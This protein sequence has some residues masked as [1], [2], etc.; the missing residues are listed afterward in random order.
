[1]VDMETEHWHASGTVSM[2]QKNTDELAKQN[3]QKTKNKKQNKNI[4]SKS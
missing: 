3:K 4:T 1:M 2:K